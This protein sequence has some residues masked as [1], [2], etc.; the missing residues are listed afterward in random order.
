MAGS[1]EIVEKQDEFT[2]EIN[3]QASMLMIPKVIGKAYED[4]K[5][6]M[7]Q[8][9]IPCEAPPFVKYVNFS[10]DE[11]TGGNK[12]LGFFKM[13]T[14][15]WDMQ[16]GFPVKN[17]TPGEG[18][19]KSGKILYGKYIQTLHKGSYQKV[20]STYKILMAYMKENNLKVRNECM[21]TYLNDPK[22]TKKEDLQTLVVIP[23][24]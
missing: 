14:K 11:S 19:I 10:W 7:K 16:I 24:S 8:K 2:L 23:L 20:G 15:K 5:K 12:F 13:F 4:L 6:F 1:V 22:I 21:E 9:G 18:S 17:D 3:A